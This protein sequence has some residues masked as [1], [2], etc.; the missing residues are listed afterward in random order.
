MRVDTAGRGFYEITPGVLDFLCSAKIHSGLVTAF[1]RHTSASLSITE[2]AD[3]NVLRD[4]DAFLTR[5]APEG[6]NYRHDDE[7]PDDMPAHIRAALT[8]TQLA[9]PVL[10]GAAALGTWQGIFLIEHRR[11]P[12]RREIVLHAIGE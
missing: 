9:I 6:D 3:P 10:G 1:C 5:I 7:G 2:N 8:Q 4:L 12:H 11:R